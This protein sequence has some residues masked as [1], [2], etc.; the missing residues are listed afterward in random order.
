MLSDKYRKN[1]RRGIETP[2]CA[3]LGHSLDV[4][5]KLIPMAARV[6]VEFGRASINECSGPPPPWRGREVCP[7]R[8]GVAGR[9]VLAA[10]RSQGPDFKRHKTLRGLKERCQ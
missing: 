3:W 6:M 10:V 4:R 1:T 2:S 5:A 8:R 7:R 9:F